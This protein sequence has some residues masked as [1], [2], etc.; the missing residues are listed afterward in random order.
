MYSIQIDMFFSVLNLNHQLKKNILVVKKL[1]TDLWILAILTEN[2]GGLQKRFDV[3]LAPW[4][5]TTNPRAIFRHWMNELKQQKMKQ[6]RL[7]SYTQCS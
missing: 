6:A 7:A 3:K 1:P 4:L 2:L 5:T